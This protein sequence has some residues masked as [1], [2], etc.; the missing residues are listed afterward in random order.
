MCELRTDSTS[1]ENVAVGLSGIESTLANLPTLNLFNSYWFY[2]SMSLNSD[3]S[4]MLALG[5]E[6]K[7]FVS[8]GGEISYMDAWESNS[9]KS[10]FLSTNSAALTVSSFSKLLAERESELVID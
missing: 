5:T 7:N 4:R 10:V 1:P 9:D 2:R 3:P 8:T 6:A